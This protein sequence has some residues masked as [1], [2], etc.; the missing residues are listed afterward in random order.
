MQAHMDKDKEL[1]LLLW[2]VVIVVWNTIPS[3]LD[4]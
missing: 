3:S 1:G 4:I 2:V